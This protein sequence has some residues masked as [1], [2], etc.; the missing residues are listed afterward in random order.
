M[1]QENVKLQLNTQKSITEK[2]QNSQTISSYFNNKAQSL[3]QLNPNGNALAMKYENKVPFDY[4]RKS[5][6]VQ[7][8]NTIDTYQTQNTIQN[9]STI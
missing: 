6:N 3:S 8:F 9:F 5:V 2:S 1:T 7:Q 4:Q